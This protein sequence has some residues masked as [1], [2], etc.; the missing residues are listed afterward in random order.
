MSDAIT[1]LNLDF[2]VENSDFITLHLPI[3]KN[4]KNLFN[5]DRM[6]KMKKTARIIN[7]ARGG[8]INESDLAR[9]L[10]DDIIAGAAIDVFE[11]E[12]IDIENQLIAA[13]NILLTPHLGASTVEAKEGVNI[14]NE[15]QTY[16]S[17]TF[18]NYFR[19]FNKLSGMT[20][21]ALTE[22]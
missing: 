22:A 19:L 1:N 5:Y 7:V 17:I 15:N 11:N 21:T 16:A 18:Q 3:N 14:Q 20:G 4:T 8:I 13:N 2:L 9:V 10:N 12:P 6:A